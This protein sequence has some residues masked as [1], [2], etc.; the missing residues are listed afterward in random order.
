VPPGGQD[1]LWRYATLARLWSWSL[2]GS[3]AGL[4]P[5]SVLLQ[6][7]APEG[8]SARWFATLIGITGISG[9]IFY[10]L[11]RRWMSRS[12]P[13]MRLDRSDK[14]KSRVL[15]AGRSDW[16]RWTLLIAAILFVGSTMMLS[17]LV[18]VLKR[19]G[20]AE[21]V[22]IGT[23]IAWAVVT[24]EDARR[25]DRA[26]RTDG[27][28]YWASVPR[29]VAIADRLVWTGS[30]AQP[31]APTTPTSAATEPSAKRR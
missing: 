8:L 9:A 3:A 14:L 26:E 27:R 31:A 29:P 20:E 25:I 2:L 19:G 22:V 12:G 1:K 16:R 24:L 21:G 18:G 23:L 13:S 11:L 5:L 4:V 30:Q 17:F 28:R 15:E 6:A 10:P 7:T